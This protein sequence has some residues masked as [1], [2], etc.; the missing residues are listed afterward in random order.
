VRAGDSERRKL[1]R[2]LHDGV[3]QRLVAIRIDLSLAAE[4]DA[5]DSAMRS[6]LTAIGQS[7]EEALDE[8]REVSHGLYPP[9]LSDWGL[10]AALERINLR[11]GA[12]LAVRATGISRHPPDLE[13]AVYYCCLEAIQNAVKHGGPGARITVAL[14]QDAHE[15]TFHVTDD[16]PGFD[17]SAPSAGT[18][19][20]NMRDRLGA[21]DGRLSIVTEDGQGTTVTGSIPLR[22][23]DNARAERVDADEPDNEETGG[24]IAKT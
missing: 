8:L 3:Q 22:V 11:L 4:L 20:Q 5:A 15:L 23:S 2:N 17:P 16:G 10:V 1:E 19:L 12:P 6:R 9:A 7:V 13:A 14:R 18:G 21:L 24:G